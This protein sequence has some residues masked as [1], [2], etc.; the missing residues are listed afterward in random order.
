MS[1]SQCLLHISSGGHRRL[2]A[3][4]SCGIFHLAFVFGKPSAAHFVTSRSIISK[5][6]A[7]EGA[8]VPIC[9]G[10]RLVTINQ[11]KLIDNSTLAMWLFA[12]L[13]QI[14]VFLSMVGGTSPALKKTMLDLVTNFGAVSDSQAGTKTGGSYAMKDLR[15]HGGQKS[16]QLSN[17][18]KKFVPFVGGSSSNNALIG[19]RDSD[20]DNDNDSQKGI[21]RRDEIEISY[22]NTRKESY[23]NNKW[24]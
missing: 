2:C 8:S 1:P 11:R 13:S 17:A 12:V 10:L 3:Q 24:I 15:Y 20:R 4:G 6:Y 16:G 5:L 21:I 23:T 9:A 19:R 7:D 22:E 14:Q 18:G